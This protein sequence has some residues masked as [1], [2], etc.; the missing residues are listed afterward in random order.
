MKHR[1]P[2]NLLCG[3]RLGLEGRS[4]ISDSAGRHP[5]RKSEERIRRLDETL[6]ILVRTSEAGASAGSADLAR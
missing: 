2:N 6:S 1:L 4:S 5:A 3:T